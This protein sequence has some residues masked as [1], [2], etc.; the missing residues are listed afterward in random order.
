MTSK[1]VTSKKLTGNLDF[2]CKTFKLGWKLL[3]RF[4]IHV[5]INK[6]AVDIKWKL[7]KNYRNIL[8]ER[9]YLIISR[10]KET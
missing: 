7:K 8:I 2:S 9:Y 4:E 3:R 1:T 10:F 6:S 5:I